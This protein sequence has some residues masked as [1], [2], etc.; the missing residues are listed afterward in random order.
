MSYI[1]PV[2]W[3]ICTSLTI[4][5]LMT[6]RISG[7]VSRWDTWDWTSLAKS[8]LWGWLHAANCPAAEEQSWCCRKYS[9]VLEHVSWIEAR[10]FREQGPQCVC[11][12][13]RLHTPRKLLPCTLCACIIVRSAQGFLGSTVATQNRWAMYA[14]SFL[15][16]C[17]CHSNTVVLPGCVSLR[18]LACYSDKCTCMVVMLHIAESNA[19]ALGTAVCNACFL[20]LPSDVL[21]F[22]SNSV[23]ICP[24]IPAS[25]CKKVVGKFADIYI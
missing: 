20:K 4:C 15:F 11:Q 12:E 18:M 21:Q 25:C 3:I 1:G 14:C 10:A 23:L 13:A 17:G 24:L 5:I 6:Y 8:V 9:A 22:G 7:A 2:K 16:E 19:Y